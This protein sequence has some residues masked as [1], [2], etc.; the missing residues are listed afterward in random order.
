[1]VKQCEKKFRFQC[2]V[3]TKR[4]QRAGSIL[5]GPGFQCAVRAVEDHPRETSGTPTFPLENLDDCCWCCRSS[6]EHSHLHI[7]SFEGVFSWG[8]YC[9]VCGHNS[10]FLLEL[11][12]APQNN[13]IY[14]RFGIGAL[15]KGEACESETTAPKNEGRKWGIEQK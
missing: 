3:W 2:R 14:K 7:P 15:T 9:V 1:M 4:E 8:V 11:V 5:M 12:E 13:Y 10:L 6:G